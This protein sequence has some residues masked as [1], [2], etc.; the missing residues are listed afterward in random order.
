[1]D[2]TFSFGV[3]PAQGEKVSNHLR[4][5]EKFS[6]ALIEEVRAL[7]AA[8]LSEVLADA[9]PMPFLLTESEIAGVLARR[10]DVVSYV[11]SLIEKHGQDKVLVFP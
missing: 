8:S 11:D 4:R 2:N 1:M 10:D 7:T 9:G 3:G 5:T 6:R